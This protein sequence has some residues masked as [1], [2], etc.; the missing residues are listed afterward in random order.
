MFVKSNILFLIADCIIKC[1]VYC[2]YNDVRVLK[3]VFEVSDDNMKSQ[4]DV[5]FCL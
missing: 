3:C 1:H 4:S 2:V 5:P